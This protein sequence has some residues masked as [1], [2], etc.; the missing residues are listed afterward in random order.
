M[1]AV[2][3]DIPV[4]IDTSAQREASSPRLD[5]IELPHRARA[6]VKVSELHN[7]EVEMGH[8]FGTHTGTRDETAG[9]SF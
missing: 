4:S 5:D 6:M 9:Q 3:K 8:V 7:Q 1:K 2:R